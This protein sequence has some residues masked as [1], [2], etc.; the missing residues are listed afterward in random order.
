[1]EV[2]RR[3]E[4][5]PAPGAG[6]CRL[7]D[8]PGQWIPSNL[9]CGTH[10]GEMFSVYICESEYTQEELMA[11]RCMSIIA[12]IILAGM[13]LGCSTDPEDVPPK[14]RVHNERSTNASLQVKTSGG[15]TININNVQSGQTTEYQEVAEGIVQVTVTIQ[16]ETGDFKGSFDAQKNRLFTVAVAN[17][18][19]PAVRI[20]VR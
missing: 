12:G 7:P 16:G 8:D 6:I 13:L 14:F 17:T 20:D 18:T 4:K 9:C 11:P 5:R 3:P 1:M 19:P 15:N 2:S 10:G